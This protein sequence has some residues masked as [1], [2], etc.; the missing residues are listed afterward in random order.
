M[1]K[2]LIFGL[3]GSGKTTL[4]AELKKIIDSDWINADQVRRKFNDWDFSKKGV[5]RQAKRMKSLA[6]KSKKNFVV[7]DFVCPYREGRKIFKPD[8]LVWMDTVKKGRLSTFNKSFQKP[9]KYDF[10]A[11]IKNAK[12]HA[13]QISNSLK[14]YKWD[15]KKETIKIKKPTKKN[16]KNIR[17]KC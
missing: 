2:I 1:K 9:L 17:Y 16:S 4:A 13:I 14:T 11:N 8:Y 5:L 3:P 7:A 6:N 12:L 15:N 10:K